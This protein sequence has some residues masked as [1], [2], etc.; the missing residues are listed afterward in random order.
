M[1]LE[2]HVNAQRWL[3]VLQDSGADL[4]QYAKQENKLHSG[5]CYVLQQGL[6]VTR[7]NIGRSGLLLM[8]T[9]IRYVS[10]LVL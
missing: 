1:Y 3:R 4:H 7:M 2:H 6:T 8:L 10:G 5:S 9:V